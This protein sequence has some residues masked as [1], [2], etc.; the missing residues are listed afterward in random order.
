M[1]KNV[2]MNI[3]ASARPLLQKQAMRELLDPRLMNCYS[4][5]EVYCMAL[6]AYL[7]IRRDPNSRPRMSQVLRM[8]EGDVVMSPI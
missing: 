3:K 1:G 2:Q 5:Q 4:E 7:C 8:L 6:C